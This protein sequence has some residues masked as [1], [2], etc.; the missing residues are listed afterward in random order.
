MAKTVSGMLFGLGV[1]LVVCSIANRGATADPKAASAPP[2]RVALIDMAKVFKNSRLF[3]SKRDALK[4]QIT[5]TEES[6]KSTQ[7][8]LLQMKKRLDALE[9]GTDKRADLEVTLKTKTAEFEK[10]RQSAQKRFLKLEAEIY[11]EIYDL[12]TTTV[13][14]HAREHDIDLVV[15]FKSDPIAE[16]DPA[17]M[18]EE[19]NRLVIYETGLD[20]TDEIIAAIK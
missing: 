3:L 15:R 20:I 17:K 5:E 9:Q 11:R 10:F 14:N 18:L 4:R 19:F 2:T 12:I 8:E 1:L 16:D 6:A 13:A 7:T